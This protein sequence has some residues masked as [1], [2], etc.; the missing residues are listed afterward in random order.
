MNKLQRA[1]AAMVTIPS[2]SRM[3]SD[4]Q[5]LL[6]DEFEQIAS[7]QGQ[8]PD[9]ISSQLHKN[10]R[11]RADVI[12]KLMKAAQLLRVEKAAMSRELIDGVDPAMLT[13]EQILQIVKDDVNSSTLANVPADSDSDE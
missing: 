13:N 10:A 11:E 12:L 9:E 2:V 5:K 3:L 6:A 8:E 7:L 4:A 1:Q